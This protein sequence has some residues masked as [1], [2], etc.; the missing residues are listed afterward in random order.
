MVFNKNT[1]MNWRPATLSELI[2]SRSKM[3]HRTVFLR[4][5]EMVFYLMRFRYLEIK[6]MFYIRVCMA[7]TSL[8]L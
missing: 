2:N 6:I 3:L 1:Y 7:I 5:Y 8:V 4:N